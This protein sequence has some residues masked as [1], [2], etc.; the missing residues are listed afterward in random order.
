MQCENCRVHVNDNDTFCRACGSRITLRS[1]SAGNNS[2]ATTRI[3]EFANLPQ[4]IE[5]MQSAAQCVEQGDTLTEQKKYLE[6]ERYYREAD[7]LEPDNAEYKFY[8]GACLCIQRKFAAGEVLY[9]DALRIEPNNALLLFSLGGALEGQGRFEQ[10]EPYFT[11]AIKLE[12]DN[13]MYQFVMGWALQKQ[14]R[15][16]EAA[17]YLRQAVNLDPE[18]SIYRGQLSALDRL[19][20]ER[21]VKS[22]SDAVPTTT[23]SQYDTIQNRQV[24]VPSRQHLGD[25][26][27]RN[28]AAR[29]EQMTT[30]Q[31]PVPGCQNNEFNRSALYCPYCGLFNRCY[32]MVIS[33]VSNFTE[34]CKKLSARQQNG[35]ITD[36]MPFFTRCNSNFET[37]QQFYSSP[38]MFRVGHPNVVFFRC[39][40]C[41]LYSQNDV[42]PLM[43]PEKF[44]HSTVADFY[45]MGRRPDYSIR[46]KLEAARDSMES[47]GPNLESL[48]RL[49]SGLTEGPD[50]Y[51]PYLQ[52]LG[53]ME[54]AMRQNFAQEVQRRTTE[55]QIHPQRPD[56]RSH[57]PCPNC[58][59]TFPLI[60]KPR[61]D[62]RYDQRNAS[63]HNKHITVIEQMLASNFWVN[64][65]ERYDNFLDFDYFFKACKI[66]INPGWLLYME[67]MRNNDYPED[68]RRWS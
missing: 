13:A 27:S 12:S 31:C 54:Q 19:L 14:D 5:G 61:G 50:P 43:P 16:A 32:D 55:M 21:S 56:A 68:F 8:L 57:S 24:I 10:A 29:N 25:T 2:L 20:A 9:R 52:Q 48:Q 35:E 28:H 1:I 34:N 64:V 11:K 49:A 37:Y 3:A 41:D 63:N 4:E 38:R 46:E 6:A 39:W 42:P 7:R 18:N 26:D 59:T 53:Q 44:A 17:L 47:R 60:L 65:G 66:T 58:G 40:H 51:R 22:I 62:N 45:L 15:H 36:D 23:S 30:E 67:K 33:F